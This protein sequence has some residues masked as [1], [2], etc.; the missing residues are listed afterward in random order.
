MGYWQDN[1]VKADTGGAEPGRADSTDRVEP[2]QNHPTHEFGERI[3]IL[4]TVRAETGTE[5]PAGQ[6]PAERG[7]ALSG[8]GKE[9]D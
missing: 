8:A 4:S 6:E 5:R 9:I 2:R 1:P 3:G 7:T